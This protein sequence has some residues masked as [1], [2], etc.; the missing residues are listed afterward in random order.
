MNLSQLRQKVKDLISLKDKN[1]KLIDDLKKERSVLQKANAS[2]EK[3][4][5]K[6]IAEL[7]R[8]LSD[9]AESQRNQISAI[10]HVHAGEIAKKGYYNR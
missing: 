6:S 2:L 4:N 3:A 9:L 10:R 8:E 7:N 1:K 5:K